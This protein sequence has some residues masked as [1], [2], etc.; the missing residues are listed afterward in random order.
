MKKDRYIYPAVFDYADDG[1][2]I[3]FPDLPGCF[4]CA[5]T[6]EE[7]I[8]MAKE[9][10]GLHLYGMEE[11]GEDM[12]VP[13]TINKINLESHQVVV[14]VEVLMPIVREAVENFSVKKTLSIPQWLNKLAI[15]NNINFSQVLQSA[16]KEHLGIR[17]RH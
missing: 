9:A 6:D 2:S 4:S 16:L 13:T 5:D 3:F 17:E 14:L 11:D 8:Y 12:P 10:L 1:I 15:D 7:A